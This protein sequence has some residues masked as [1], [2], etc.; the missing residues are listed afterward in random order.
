MN[1]TIAIASALAL[2]C[3][4]VTLIVWL[5]NRVSKNK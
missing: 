4:A 2:Y 1:E 3:D 5:V